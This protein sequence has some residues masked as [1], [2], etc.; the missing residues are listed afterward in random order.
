MKK[1]PHGYHRLRWDD[2]E[3]WF[4]D[5]IIDRGHKYQMKGRVSD[6][7]LTDNGDLIAWVS[8]TKRYAT[9]IEMTDGEYL[10]SYCT[11]PY[12]INCKHGVAVVLEYLE[13]L[14]KNQ[15]VPVW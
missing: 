13:C 3:D 14:K 9:T 1:I 7:S 5:A 10:D 12:A 15:A 8:G 4:E 2:L 11:C 6:L